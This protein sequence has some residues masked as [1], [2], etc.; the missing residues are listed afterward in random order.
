LEGQLIE[1][2][3]WQT[4]KDA[5]AIGEHPQR[6]CKGKSHFCVVACG[7]S[8]IGNAPVRGHRLARPNGTWFFRR[9]IT[10]RKNE[11]EFWSV[12][13]RKL[14]QLFARNPLTS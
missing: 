9:I 6:I 13:T 3:H 4:D 7:L 12:G 1:R 11:I 5:D 2:L 10:D 14:F 8:R